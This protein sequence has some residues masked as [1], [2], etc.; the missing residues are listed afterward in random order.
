M[1]PFRRA[2][3]L[4][5]ACLLNLCLTEAQARCRVSLASSPTEGLIGKTNDSFEIG[6][7][8]S[9]QPFCLLALSTWHAF[10]PFIAGPPITPTETENDVGVLSC[11]HRLGMSN[12]LAFASAKIARDGMVLNAW[13][14][15]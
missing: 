5:R 6:P 11:L 15:R 10:R 14:E 13:N 9:I 8:L 2:D 3:L 1:I 12:Q 4:A 7:K